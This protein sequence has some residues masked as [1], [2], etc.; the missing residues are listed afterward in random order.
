[1][2]II[3]LTAVL[4]KEED[5]YVVECPEVGTVSQGATVEEATANL[6]EAT[7]LCLEEFSLPSVGRPILTTFDAAE[8]QLRRL[9]EQVAQLSID[10]SMTRAELR[11]LSNVV[12]GKVS[13]A[14]VDPAMTGL[15]EDIRAARVKL[16]EAQAAADEEWG[17][18]SNDLAESVEDLRSQLEGDAE[19][20]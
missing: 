16:E 12:E 20:E 18:L 11:A 19:E 15:N 5:L 10:L 17:R 3:T 14:E 9:V 8:R 13:A 1:M 4:H 2:A 7:E 6:K